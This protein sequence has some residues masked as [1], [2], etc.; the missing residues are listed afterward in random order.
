[1][2][3][4]G[5]LASETFNSVT[6]TPVYTPTADTFAVVTVSICNKNANSIRVRLAAAINPN[7]PDA[8]QY[9]EYETE[10]LPNGVLERTG[11]ILQSGRTLY[12]YSTGPTGST[13][14]DAS[15]TDVV[16]YGIETS[17]A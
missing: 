8:G 4:T 16:V 2:A 13:N 17:T 3:N 6:Y 1:M 10:I 11:I 5:I 15:Q 9:L 14:T 12:A 7:I